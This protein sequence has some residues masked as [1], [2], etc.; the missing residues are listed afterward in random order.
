MIKYIK[1]IIKWNSVMNKFKEN[2]LNPILKGLNAFYNSTWFIAFFAF[3]VVLSW[4]VECEYIAVISSIL[5]LCYMFLTQKHLDGIAV[6]AII[7]P[8][9]VDDNMRHR[10]SFSQIYLLVGL[11]C[12]VVACAVYYFKKVYEKNDRKITKGYFFLVYVLCAVILCFSGLG[13]EGNTFF[14]VLIPVGVH[15][16]LLGLYVLL[17]KCGGRNLRDVIIK[18]IIALA[19][20]VSIETII[21]LMRSDNVFAVL[22]TKVM[23][24]GWAITN[25]V[26]VILAFAV[27]LCFYLAK[28]KKVQLPYML[29]GSLLYASIFLTNCRSMI[30]FG[31]AVYVLTIILS[32]I[33]LDRWQAAL[34]L[35]LFMIGAVFAV[36]AVFEQ[37]FSYFLRVGLDDTGRFELYSYYW[38][39]FKENWL[40]GMGF[41][42]DT[43][44]QADGMVRVHNTI[45]QIFASMGIVGV[46]ASIPYFYKRYRAFTIKLTPFKIFAFVA[47]L[48]MVGYGLVD[49]TIISSYKLIVIA[50]LM[51]AVEFDSIFAEEKDLLFKK[52][53]KN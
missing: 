36:N 38:G 7:I 44:Y 5:I 39:Q 17:Y 22:N 37:I 24:L 26:A 40:F 2:I 46:V 42:T 33:Y 12:L 16:A 10:I 13:Y 4:A 18:S 19:C 9:M 11:L 8:A 28:D 15:A 35:A 51:T 21:Y 29:L 20:I 49:C 30:I 48:A 41:Y 52:S 27:P 50:M 25:S 23:S 34:H 53:V 45:I 3:L 31:T 43:V 6:I 1:K 32:F 14:K 47:Y